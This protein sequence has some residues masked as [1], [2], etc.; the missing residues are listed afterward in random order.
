MNSVKNNK[1]IWA[2]FILLTTFILGACQGDKDPQIALQESNVKKALYCM[3]LL[4]NQQDLETVRRECFGDTYMQ[5]TPWIPDGV[6]EVLSI[7]AKRF[8]KYPDFAM[9]IKR[10]AASDDLVWIHL[11]TKRVPDV[12]GNAVINIFR[13][14]DGKF[15][16]HWNVV[17]GVPE[18]SANDNTMF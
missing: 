10:S 1:L 7:F 14:Q 4:E 13:M 6:D 2:L 11:H 9:E 16:E 5:H 15:V 8:E 17:Q 3:D 12:L 18:K